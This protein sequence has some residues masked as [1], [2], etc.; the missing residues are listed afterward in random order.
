MN[1][2]EIVQLSPLEDAAQAGDTT[3][4]VDLLQVD[5]GEAQVLSLSELLKAA[6]S[7]GIISNAAVTVM[8]RWAK[9][10]S[11]LGTIPNETKSHVTL[12]VLVLDD[13]GSL[14]GF[15]E[16]L[17]NAYNLFV[18]KMQEE[19]TSADIFVAVVLLNRGLLIPYTRHTELRLLSPSDIT[20]RE[21]DETPLFSRSLETLSQQTADATRLIEQGIQARTITLMFTD[22]KASDDRYRSDMISTVNGLVESRFSILSGISCGNAIEGFWE[23]IGVPSNWVL[24]TDNMDA[25]RNAFGAFSRSASSASRGASAFIAAKAGGIIRKHNDGF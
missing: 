17:I 16:Q 12:M 20:I 21:C 5:T 11:P 15:K 24:T 4:E 13:S 6:S 2:N 25:L 7:T 8:S 10:S 3:D 19:N 9:D 23:S 14:L 22:G 18:L 1:P